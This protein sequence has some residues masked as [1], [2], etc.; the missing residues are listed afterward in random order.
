MWGNVMADDDENKI[1]D[2]SETLY[3]SRRSRRDETVYLT[4]RQCF[5][6]WSF[7]YHICISLLL[8]NFA[9]RQ[10]FGWT[11]DKS[12]LRWYVANWS[13][14]VTAPSGHLLAT[15]LGEVC[16]SSFERKKVALESVRSCDPTSVNNNSSTQA[17]SR[18]S[19]TC[20]TNEIYLFNH[21][22]H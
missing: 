3:T 16:R 11:T 7:T 10:T 5:D 21:E 19:D 17:G 20:C 2:I 4:A 1:W 15:E 12:R 6:V 13:I 8:R 9:F 14:C 22:K 18:H